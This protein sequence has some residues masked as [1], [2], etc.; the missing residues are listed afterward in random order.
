MEGLGT[1]GECLQHFENWRKVIP[2]LGKVEKMP[3][4]KE[5]KVQ[6]T[7]KGERRRGR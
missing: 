7:Q 2:R 4:R 3:R 5:L 1:G 6:I